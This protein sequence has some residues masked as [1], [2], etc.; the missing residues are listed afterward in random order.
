LRVKY[1]KRYACDAF[2]AVGVA[3]VP[4]RTHVAKKHARIALA[5][6]NCWSVS[7]PA[8]LIWSPTDPK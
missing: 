6:R 2:V 8:R 3:D 5:G 4:G 7:C 1:E